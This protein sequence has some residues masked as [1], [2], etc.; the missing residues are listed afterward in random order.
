LRINKVLV[1]ISELHK[2]LV[3]LLREYDNKSKDNFPKIYGEALKKIWE[4][5]FDLKAD[6]YNDEVK[7]DSFR[8]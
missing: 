4:L 6:H 7:L 2:L 8:K 5:Y 1:Q 3:K